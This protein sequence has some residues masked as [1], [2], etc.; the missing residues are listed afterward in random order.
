MSVAARVIL[1][2]SRRSATNRKPP[3]YQSRGP[4]SSI[5]R[6]K[7]PVNQLELHKNIKK[8]KVAP[9]DAED[10]IIK[11]RWDELGLKE[12]S[13]INILI[14]NTMPKINSLIQE[15]NTHRELLLLK[16]KYKFAKAT[17]TKM[18]NGEITLAS[19]HAKYS[20]H[21]LIPFQGQSLETNVSENIFRRQA[22]FG[23]FLIQN[24]IIEIDKAIRKLLTSRGKTRRGGRR[25]NRKKG[26]RKR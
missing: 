23:L 8:R 17:L 3:S 21:D 4:S 11:S 26:T 5:V 14:S 10:I 7:K 12:S 1:N 22:S 2:S 19:L 25:F 24:I 15:K 6:E 20:S 9:T 18:T 16:R 13:D